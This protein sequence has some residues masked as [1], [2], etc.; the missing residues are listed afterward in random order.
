MPKFIPVLIIAL[1]AITAVA[2]QTSAPA[3]DP[4]ARAQE[5]LKQ[6]Q[7]TLWGES[8]AKV[9]SLTINANSKSTMG[10]TDLTVEMVLPDKFLFTGTA[11][12]G[13]MIQ[14]I[15]G[16]E[17]WSDF[18]PNNMGGGGG[19]GGGGFGGGGGGSSTIGST[20][21][22][23]GGGGGRSGRSGRSGGGGGFGG[24]Q[25]SGGMRTP[26]SSDF[27]RLLLS[28]LLLA[29]ASVEA[30]FFY[31]GATK[32]DG[33]PMDVI[34][35]KGQNNFAARLYIDAQTHQLFLM[36]YKTKVMSAGFGITQQAAGQGAGQST[37]PA[38]TQEERA[39]T[40]ETE[41]RWILTD[42]RSETGLNVPHRLIKMQD[43]Q[44]IEQID[45]KKVKI[46]PS[47]KPE[48][49]VKKEEKK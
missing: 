17:T 23:V 21:T 8:Q 41:V 1:A 45:I 6:A 5:V 40:P 24:G 38:P 11:S 25:R 31:A 26:N 43:G 47:I 28:W 10:E 46:N 35:A 15:N 48:K 29:P 33:K 44:A 39:N 9:Q 30:E 18:K 14:A 19:G 20:D 32:A 7:T 3:S 16:T 13:T 4:K 22:G 34:D 42:Y 12:F 49:F 36:T 27:G 37:P 2:Q